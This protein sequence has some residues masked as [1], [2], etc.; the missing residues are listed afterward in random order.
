M[1]LAPE[2]RTGFSIGIHSGER[3]VPDPHMILN[4]SWEVILFLTIGSLAVSF[5]SSRQILGKEKAK[6]K[7]GKI[8]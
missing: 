6:G 5:A 7:N 2:L 8:M 3:I 4:L 1:F